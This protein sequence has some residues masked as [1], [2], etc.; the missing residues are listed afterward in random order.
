MPSSPREGTRFLSKRW[1]LSTRI[2]VGLGLGIATGLFFGEPMGAL[3]IVGDAYVKLLQMTVLPY[4]VVSLI[5]GFGQLDRTQVRL[6]AIR[7]GILLAILWGLAYLLVL[8]MPLAFPT[9]ES[10]SFFSTTLVE[11]PK[12]IDVVNLYIPSNPFRSMANNLV[13]AVVLFSI[14]MGIALIGLERKETFVESLSTLS[15][16]LLRI[17]DFVVR[18]T[19]FGVFAIGASAAGTMS[20]EEFERV[21][22]YLL[23]YIVFALIMTFWT[24][25]GLLAALT[26]MRHRTVLSL[27]RDAL[28]TAFATGND[29]VILPLLVERGTQLLKQFE[30]ERED[31]ASIVN[32]VVPVSHSFPHVAKVLTLSFVVFAGWFADVPLSVDEYATLAISGIVSLFGSVNVAIPFLLGLLRI[33]EDLFQFFVATAVLNARFGTLLATMHKLALALLVTCAITGVLTLRW[34]RLLRYGVVTVF[35]VTGAIVG[36]RLLF[37]WSMRIEYD[38]HKLLSEMQLLRDTV[39]AVVHKTLPPRSQHDPSRTRLDLIRERGVLRVGYYPENRLPFA[40]FNAR[41]EL[42]GFDIEM[43]HSLARGLGVTLEFIPLKSEFE[44]AQ[45]RS[46]AALNTGTCDIIMSLSVLSMTHVTQINHSRPYLDLTLALVVKDHRRREFTK[47][48]ALV[49]RDDLRIA[50][51]D[52]RYY[53]S[54]VHHFFPNATLVPIGSIRDFFDETAGR[55]DALAL[56][57]EIGSAWSLLYPGYTVVVPQP[58]FQNVPLVYRLPQGETDWRN[59]V[60]S[61]IEL[62]K[63]DGTIEQLYDYW[64]LG[65]QATSPGPRWSV[66]RDVLHWID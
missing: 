4:V 33:P 24:L 38:K 37:A 13:P 51:P 48:K 22:V 32:V 45:Q 3:A 30:L 60:D 66:V 20:V 14:A 23:T 17:N 58:P 62:K 41:G 12:S 57:A 52:D 43:A 1:S 39:P 29:F 21:Q 44:F 64:I 26:S 59:A 15:A 47:R 53:R 46:M 34:R 36:L 16:A 65:R 49:A 54:R 63:R 40:F 9:I 11:P 27:T 7:G 6:L 25:P 50:I 28:V 56:L 8:V 10:A 19:P 2:F 35:I 18:L 31:S 61:W 5:A 55:P 42:V